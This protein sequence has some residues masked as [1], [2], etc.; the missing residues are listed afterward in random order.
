[1]K[2]RKAIYCFL[3]SLTTMDISIFTRTCAQS[4]HHPFALYVGGG[5]NYYFNNLEVGKN[6]IQCLNYS[7]VGRLM[8]EPERFISLGIESGYYQ[9]FTA[10]YTTAPGSSVRISKLALPIQLVASTKLHQNYYVNLS[11]GQTCI[12]SEVNNLNLGRSKSSSWS[13][14]DFGL[15]GGYRH[16]FKSR[17]VL[18]AEAKLFYSSKNADSNVALAVLVGYKF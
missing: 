3:L 7:V 2:P 1:M 11:I 14:A 12:K 15:S 4:N 8:W 6:T 9:L 5:P 17:L 10:N 18:C 13:L 16:V